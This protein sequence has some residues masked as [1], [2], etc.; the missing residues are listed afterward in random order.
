MFSFVNL[1]IK[2]LIVCFYLLMATSCEF[3]LIKTVCAL[4]DTHTNLRIVWI[5]V[6][7]L[8]AATKEK[9]SLLQAGEVNL[10]S[11]SSLLLQEI[12]L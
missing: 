12:R 1:V 5:L 2:E 8:R 7:V 3:A 11:S 10:S 4:V 6:L 9:P